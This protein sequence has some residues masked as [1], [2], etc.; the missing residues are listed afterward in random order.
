MNAIRILLV[1]GTAIIVSCSGSSDFSG[2]DYQLVFISHPAGLESLWM[3]D[4]NGLGYQQ[5]TPESLKVYYSRFSLSPDGNSIAFAG[6]TEPG[7]NPSIYVLARLGR[8]IHRVT[9]TTHYY[10]FP[11]WL[12][13]GTELIFLSDRGGHRTYWRSDLNGNN[14]RQVLPDSINPSPTFAVSPSGTV[15]AFVKD[16][17][18]TTFD[19]NS[20]ELRTLTSDSLYVSSDHWTVVY[21]P[22]GEHMAFVA[23]STPPPQWPEGQ[24]FTISTT[25]S[26]IRRWTDTTQ[27]YYPHWSPSSSQVS[28]STFFGIYAVNIYTGRL[29]KVVSFSFPSPARHDWSPDGMTI[30][31]EADNY[32]VIY[33]VNSSGGQPRRATSSS[34]TEASPRWLP[35]YW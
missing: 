15:I 21:S 1:A 3:V 10:D 14:M 7:T 26:R 12:S 17:R 27:V 20:G 32:R 34:T 35:V 19:V 30:A 25:G 22:D 4:R 5:L 23:T 29:L 16:R 9:T 28:F 2:L 33:L 31:Y 8:F 11:Q 6:W 13:G 24:L 18:L